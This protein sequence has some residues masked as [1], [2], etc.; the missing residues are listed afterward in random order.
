LDRAALEWGE[1]VFLVEAAISDLLGRT[2]LL[3]FLRNLV[4]LRSAKTGKGVARSRVIAPGQKH[5]IGARDVWLRFAKPMSRPLAVADAHS[6]VG[7]WSVSVGSLSASV[8]PS[9]RSKTAPII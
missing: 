9:S 2:T 3:F 1:V 5:S 4:W 7:T 8:D 6:I